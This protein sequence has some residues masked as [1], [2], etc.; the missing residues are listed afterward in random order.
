MPVVEVEVSKVNVP[1]TLFEGVPLE[2]ETNLTTTLERESEPENLY[3][4]EVIV[5]AEGMFIWLAQV[6]LLTIP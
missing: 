4:T 6:K 3:S 1:S 5:A 2:S